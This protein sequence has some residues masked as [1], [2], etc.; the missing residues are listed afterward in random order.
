MKV[1]LSLIV[2]IFWVV[3]AFSQ[4]LVVHY[5]SERALSEARKAA[6]MQKNAAFAEVLELIL[7]EKQ[8][9]RLSHSQG[10]SYYRAEEGSERRQVKTSDGIQHH[11]PP[12]NPSP[13]VFKRLNQKQLHYLFDRSAGSVYVWDDLPEPDWRIRADSTREIAGYTCQYAEGKNL[14]GNPVQ[15]WFAPDIPVS[16]GPEDLHGL[17]GLILEARTR[18]LRIRVTKITFPETLSVTLPETR[19][20]AIT[21]AEF[22]EQQENLR[23]KK[24]RMRSEVNEY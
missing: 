6:I 8:R 9:L 21:L 20:Q 1:F 13:R 23:K 24:A 12:K 19:L 16:D 22:R 10:V 15:V 11:L 5:E 17:P 2:S 4:Q 18:G 7:N 3:N 14:Y